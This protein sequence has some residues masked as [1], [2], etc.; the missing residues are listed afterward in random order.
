MSR[1]D[2]GTRTCW[3]ETTL[4]A[5]GGVALAVWLW[6]TDANTRGMRAL[7]SANPAIGCAS[8]RT[9]PDGSDGAAR[10]LCVGPVLLRDLPPEQRPFP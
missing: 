4:I 1:H 3:V 9:L 6:D 10:V 5:A 8:G 7:A 2:P